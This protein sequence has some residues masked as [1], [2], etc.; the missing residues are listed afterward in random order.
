MTLPTETLMAYVDGE[1][2]PEERARVEAAI[3]ADADLQA[4][5]AQQHALRRGLH[6]AFDDVLATPVP[7][8]LLAAAA[9]P[10][11]W[12]F[13]LRSLGAR[14]IALWSGIPAAAALACG[15]VLGVFLGGPSGDVVSGPGGLMA[16][17][18]LA[19]ALTHQLAAHP[20]RTAMARIGITFKDKAGRFCRT[21]TAGQT[22][23]IACHQGGGWHIAALAQSA[24]EPGADDAYQTAGSTMPD[25]IRSAV[26]GLIA[27]PALDAK[28]ERAARA[29]G[30]TSR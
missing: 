24:P 6:D 29:A 20:E 4:F 14:R 21:F 15:L 13:R 23:G 5:V 16:R 19:A 28:A 3:T 7:E 25:P 1:L 8:A 18:P 27:G 10:P 12:R 22:A 17:G 30:W 26:Q 11:S 9:K 2:P